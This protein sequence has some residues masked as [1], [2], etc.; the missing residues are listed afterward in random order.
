M[1]K[2]LILLFACLSLFSAFAQTTPARHHILLS[3]ASFASPENGWFEMGCDM[4]GAFAINRAT[5]GESIVNTANKMDL[6]VLYSKK[7]LETLDAFVIMQVH[8]RNVADETGLLKNYKDYKTPFTRSNY[9]AAF[10]YVIKR[11]INDCYELRNEPDSKYFGSENGKPVV[12]ILCTDWHDART[13]YNNSVRKLAEKWNFPLV[14]FDKNIGFT[15][16]QVHPT[17]KL[18][19][20]IMYSKDTQE[21]DGVFYGL[22][23]Y[24]GKSAMIQQRMAAIFAD[25]MRTILPER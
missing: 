12:I 1:K 11:Y 7:E 4:L 21:I 16:D 6:G 19:V 18:Q 3:G 15:K 17:T 8:N 22:H 25:R 13:L 2:G 23:P 20:S 14:E 9:A 5:D 10:D 24:R